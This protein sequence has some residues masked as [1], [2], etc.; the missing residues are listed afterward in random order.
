MAKR[1]KR[2]MQD[3]DTGV[4]LEEGAEEHI[5][6]CIINNRSKYTIKTY[7]SHWKIF[8]E[9]LKLKY[10]DEEIEY[11]YQI[12][13]TMLTD[14]VLYLREL[15]PSISDA[16]VNSNLRSLRAILY[17]FMENNYL[18]EFQIK[19]VTE[20]L[21]EKVP[22]SM[23]DQIKLLYPP[24][25][26]ATFEQYRNWVITYHFF[27][28]GNRSRTVRNIKMKH[29]SFDKQIIILEKTK[30]KKVYETPI[31]QD[32]FPVLKDYYQER[33]GQGAKPDDYLFCT[34]YG[35]KFTADGLRSSM[36]KYFKSRGVENTSL[37]LI[38]HTFATEWI[39]NDG[40]TEKLQKML[41]QESDH[42]IKKYLH[43]CGKDLI[44]DVDEFSPIAKLR[45][46][47]TPKRKVKRKQ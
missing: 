46:E 33:L 42:V 7:Q 5:N 12:K 23:E 30:N 20:I 3:I 36:Y 32:Y 28:T 21:T 13:K 19:Q 41:G 4:T 34:T 47:I 11:T 1:L 2:K 44:D 16:T 24:N 29:V 6:E 37:H 40:S 10:P 31:S 38:R 35:E 27:S 39:Q 15:N 8:M 45:Q 9:F 43:L 18:E 26:D 25:S 17:Y 22:Y 14:L